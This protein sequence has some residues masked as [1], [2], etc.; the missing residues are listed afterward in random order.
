MK[1]MKILLISLTMVMV[2]CAGKANNSFNDPA[3][4]ERKTLTDKSFMVDSMNGNVNACLKA[5]EEKYKADQAKAQSMSIK[6]P[7]NTTDA[8]AVSLAAIQALRDISLGL[9]EKEQVIELARLGVPFST[10][11]LPD[12]AKL[13][14]SHMVV[15]KKRIN[16]ETLNNLGGKTIGLLKVFGYTYA[17]TKVALH[18]ADKLSEPRI[19]S[20]DGST[21]ML[22]DGNNYEPDNRTNPC[23]DEGTC[24]TPAE[25][26]ELTEMLGED[27]P[28]QEVITDPLPEDPVGEELGKILGSGI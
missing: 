21:N 27:A 26:E 2:G 4:S 17:G 1:L 8:I 19:Q 5:S 15:E 23:I 14:F 12:C 28:E 13:G 11:S 18:Y 22:G 9:I 10:N 7:T 16:H 20:G 25:E 24:V 3:T 6:E